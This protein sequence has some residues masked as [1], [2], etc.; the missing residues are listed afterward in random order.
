MCDR[1]RSTRL[2]TTS[3]YFHN[4]PYIRPLPIFLAI[5]LCKDT[6]RGRR[7]DI[8]CHLASQKRAKKTHLTIRHSASYKRWFLF[9]NLTATDRVGLHSTSTDAQKHRSNIG[10]FMKAMHPAMSN[11]QKIH[12][13]LVNC[14]MMVKSFQHIHQWNYSKN[15]PPA[16]RYALQTTPYFRSAEGVNIVY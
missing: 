14:V 11:F 2:N 7:V 5:S 15:N 16:L 3:P 9:Q 8:Y 4:I 1:F 10:A 6:T 13:Q 12:S